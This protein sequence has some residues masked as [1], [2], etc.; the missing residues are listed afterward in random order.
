MYLSQ[1][2]KGLCAK[3]GIN[4][5][6][7]LS[8]FQVED[9]HELSIFDLEAVCEEY[10]VDFYALLF[11]PLFK[12]ELYKKKLAKIKFV[13]TD[14]DGVLTDG[15]M[16]VSE[17]GDEMKRFNTQD[18]MAILQLPHKGIQVGFLSSGFTQRMVQFRAELLG[19]KY[20]YVGRDKKLDI[21]EQWRQELQL[22]WSE[23]AY[24]GDDINDREIMQ[25]VGI[26]VCPKNAV[27]TVKSVSAIHLTRKGGDACFR[28]FVDDFLLSEPLH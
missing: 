19:V 2:I 5:Q 18:G 15:G 27:R 23:I 22:D 12:P 13:V 11:V 8:D 26:S 10:E 7:F 6:E 17:Q 20:C 24:L 14:V 28:E 21:L 4:F 9:V 16:Y 3:F 1:N 25:K